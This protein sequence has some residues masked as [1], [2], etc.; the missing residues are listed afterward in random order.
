MVW[1]EGL[2]QKKRLHQPEQWYPS[3]RGVLCRGVR[4][5][6]RGR[7]SR[8]GF[9]IEQQRAGRDGTV[10]GKGGRTLEERGK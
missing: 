1:W 7:L 9:G 4:F 5:I 8:R 6:W 10:L 3:S 2:F